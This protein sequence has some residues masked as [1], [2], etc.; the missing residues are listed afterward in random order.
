MTDVPVAF[1]ESPVDCSRAL[2]A[3]RLAAV[4]SVSARCR[5]RLLWSPGWEIAGFRGAGFGSLAEASAVGQAKRPRA[6]IAPAIDAMTV[7]A[8]RFLFIFDLPFQ[9]LA[10]ESAPASGPVLKSK[11]G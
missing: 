4:R 1:A 6:I 8:L 2:A 11:P 5:A 10:V 9:R 3:A 7:D